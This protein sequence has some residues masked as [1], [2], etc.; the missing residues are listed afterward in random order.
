MQV[1]VGLHPVLGGQVGQGWGP[2]H[3]WRAFRETNP[4]ICSK[5]TVNAAAQRGSQKTSRSHPLILPVI[6]EMKWDGMIWLVRWLVQWLEKWVQ[7]TSWFWQSTDF[8]DSAQQLWH[9]CGI[10]G[11]RI[12]VSHKTSD[13]CTR[14]LR[15]MRKSNEFLG[16]CGTDVQYTSYDV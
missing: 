13:F 4:A 5:C 12:P 7:Y 6:W 9:F 14:L 11:R 3:R 16:N 8:L 2:T 1:Q 15:N 10:S